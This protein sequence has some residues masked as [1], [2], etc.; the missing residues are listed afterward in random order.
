MARFY[1]NICNELTPTMEPI[2]L[3]KLHSDKYK[4]VDIFMA[5]ICVICENE[6]S[7][8]LKA[9]YFPR[10]FNEMDQARCFLNSIKVKGVRYNMLRLIGDRDLQPPFMKE[11]NPMRDTVLTTERSYTRTGTHKQSQT[12]YNVSL[13]RSKL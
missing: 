5:G 9:H 8:Y 3:H 4:T 13:Q 10:I 12:P 11:N 6:K 7:R 1:C 2:Y